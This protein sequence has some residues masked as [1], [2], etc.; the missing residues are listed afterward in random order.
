MRQQQSASRGGRPEP[1]AYRVE[2]LEGEA[3]MAEGDGYLSD[4]AQEHH[5]VVALHASPL[6]HRYR[7]RF[8]YII[9]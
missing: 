9:T 5:I 4:A 7:A 6:Y 2:R 3:V 1:E 8:V